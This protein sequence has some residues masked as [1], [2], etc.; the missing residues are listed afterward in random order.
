MDASF[1]S[2]AATTA[3]EYNVVDYGARPGVG[4][5]SAGAFQAAWTAACNHTLQ[6]ALRPV[7]DRNT[8]KG[9]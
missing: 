4:A 6:Y 9:Y 2:S 8:H 5:D 1:N 7:T 3:A